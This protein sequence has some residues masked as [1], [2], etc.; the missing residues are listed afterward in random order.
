MEQG[1]SSVTQVLKERLDEIDTAGFTALV[2]DLIESAKFEA[3]ATFC[4]RLTHS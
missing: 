4:L 1:S 2:F 3:S